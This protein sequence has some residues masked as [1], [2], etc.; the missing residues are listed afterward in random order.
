MIGG[1]F[2]P[3]GQHRR[4]GMPNKLVVPFAQGRRR[5]PAETAGHFNDSRYA[6]RS[7]ACSAVRSRSRPSGISDFFCGSNDSTSFN[8][9]RTTLPCA[10]L[11]AAE[12]AFRS[13]TNA[14]VRFAVGRLHG[15]DDV[16]LLDRLRGV[17]QVFQDLGP[18]VFLAD[19][20]QVG[21]DVA[22]L[23]ADL[24]AASGN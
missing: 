15:V 19:V 11:R 6:N 21:A 10:S 3:V 24:V 14:R 12:S 8:R 16:F 17:E 18:I 13:A 22:P 4:E 1:R 20:A 9:I 23:A 2:V 7:A 5:R